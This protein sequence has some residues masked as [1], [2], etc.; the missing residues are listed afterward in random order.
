MAVRGTRT[1][2]VGGAGEWRTTGIHELA[3]KIRVNTEETLVV[4]IQ[5]AGSVVQGLLV[6]TRGLIRRTH[7]AISYIM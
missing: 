4:L 2:V 1:V 3:W 7:A 6:M 5:E